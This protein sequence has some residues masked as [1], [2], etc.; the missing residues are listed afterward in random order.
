MRP[1]ALTSSPRKITPKPSPVTSYQD[2]LNRLMK[3]IEKRA[4]ELFEWRGRENG[5]DRE[6]WFKAEQEFV[7][8]VALE[9]TEKEN[10]LWIRAEVPG[11]KAE[12]LEVAFE[13]QKLTILGFHEQ[14]V[15]KAGEN[16][17]P[18]ES[19]I[20]QILRTV[21]LPAAV[22]PEKATAVLKDGVLQ[23]AAEKA[24]Q[25]KEVAAKAA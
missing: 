13:P 18:M 12:E 10:T 15:A 22:I 9:I 7:K 2:D 3:Q 8:P 11:F 1:I 17:S 19:S 16:T 6:D 20:R 24:G 5:H 23:I 14:G 4:Y 21:S 25:P